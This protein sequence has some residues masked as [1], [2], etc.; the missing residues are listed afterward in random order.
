MQASSFDIA[1]PNTP[2]YQKSFP[3]Y[4]IIISVRNLLFNRYI[5]LRCGKSNLQQT[6][7]MYYMQHLT[8]FIPMDRRHAIAN[9]TALP[10]H[11]QPFLRI[12]LGLPP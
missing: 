7:D 6:G 8:A 1:L 4:E 10:E 11:T 5:S 9:Q 3:R 12:F 2:L